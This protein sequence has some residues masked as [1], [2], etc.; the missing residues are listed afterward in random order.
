MDKAA[1]AHW[2]DVIKDTVL[3]AVRLQTPAGVAPMHDS[4]REP[5]KESAHGTV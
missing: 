5:Q 3:R 4:N 1:L 2:L